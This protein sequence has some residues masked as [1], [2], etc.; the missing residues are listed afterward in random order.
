MTTRVAVAVVVLA[1][2][3]F[4][5]DCSGTV[6]DE[7]DAGV[8][9]GT[10][11]GTGGDAGDDA[12]LDA[13]E[14]DA[15][16]DAGVDAGTPWDGGTDPLITARPYGLTVPPDYDG[17]TALPLVVMLHGF[18]ADATTQDLYFGLSNDAKAR[19]YFVAL[20]NGTFNNTGQRFWNATDACCAF[21]DTVDDVAYLTAVIDDVEH[22]YLIDQKRVYFLGHSNGG[23]MSHRMACDRSARVA[24]IASLA[25]AQW[26]DS[27]QCQPTEPVSVLEVHGTIDAVIAY[28]GGQNLG[29]QYPSASTTVR[30]WAQKN[31]CTAATPSSGPARNLEATILGDETTSDYYAGCPDG[32]AVELWSIQGG[33]HVPTLTSDATSQMVDWLFAHPKP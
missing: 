12:G 28:N 17:G 30:T 4:G 10:G 31:G 14:D 1:M 15:G 21:G 5:C 2:C 6:P 24:A 26:Q 18:S 23:F 27:S 19:G 20:P 32:G 11:G 8:D 33:G 3:G 9:A 25:G 29:V 16:V 22:R 7:T 13:G